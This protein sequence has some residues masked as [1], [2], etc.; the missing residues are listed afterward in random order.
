MSTSLPLSTMK[1]MINSIGKLI[2]L[3]LILAQL[4]SD[5]LSVRIV[6]HWITQSVD[7]SNYSNS[8]IM[9]CDY[10][11]DT[12]ED[13]K[14]VVRWFYN[15]FPEPIYQWIPESDNNRYVGQSI[16]KYFDMN[17]QIGDDRFTKYRAIRLMP[18]PSS[19]TLPFGLELSGNYTCVISSIMSQDS[20]QGQ[21]VFY[22]PP[23]KFEFNIFSNDGQL[24]LPPTND[25]ST[26]KVQNIDNDNDDDDGGGDVDN[27][28]DDDVHNG[29]MVRCSAQNVYP[30][31]VLSFSELI[32]SDSMAI[33]NMNYQ[34]PP[35]PYSPQSQLKQLFPAIDVI[36]ILNESNHQQPQLYT[37]WFEY[38]LGIDSIKVGTIYECRLEIP[39]TNYIRKKR[40]KLIYPSTYLN[41]LPSRT[42]VDNDNRWSRQYNTN[43]GQTKQLSDYQA[44]LHHHQN[45]QQR[46]VAIIDYHQMNIVIIVLAIVSAI[47]LNIQ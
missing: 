40:I 29:P 20:R 14:L 13:I 37:S 18:P 32:A 43:G 17:F 21:L 44:Q 26:K 38:R 28:N 34:R 46:N 30:K 16:R 42:V 36:T 15:D 24:N 10:Q 5:C 31:P 7:S 12:E 41:G 47:T 3:W 8:I 45:Q 4:I 27:D 33:M 19:S 25:F 11:Y 22:V 35:R 2:L 1:M 9:D 39:T 6:R 23:E